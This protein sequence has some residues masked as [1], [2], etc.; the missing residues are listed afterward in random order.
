MLCTGILNSPSEITPAHD[1]Q[2]E[3]LLCSTCIITECDNCWKKELCRI[4]FFSNQ[5]SNEKVYPGKTELDL[6]REI[7]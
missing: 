6:N 3:F 1:S 2:N 4:F 5:K 7:D